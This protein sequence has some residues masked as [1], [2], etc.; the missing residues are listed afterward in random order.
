M[1][2][3]VLVDGGIL[4]PG[5][6]D[7]VANLGADMV[8]AVKLASN[9]AQAPA[10]AKAS[11]PGGGAPSALQVLTRSMAIMQSK[12]TAQTALAATVLIEPSF[13][14]PGDWRRLRTFSTGRR[15][16]EAGVAAAEEAL[17]RLAATLPWLGSK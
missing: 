17:P 10:Y 6:G 8:I 7:A 14:D 2:S 3:Y 12:I 11:V 15:H 1:G 9:P 5:P 16:F 4:N 13:T